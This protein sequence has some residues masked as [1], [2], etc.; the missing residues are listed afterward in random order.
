MLKR[1]HFQVPVKNA[2]VVKFWT[3]TWIVNTCNEGARDSSVWSVSV[4]LS[5]VHTKCVLKT[6][7]FP[8]FLGIKRI[9]GWYHFDKGK[10]LMGKLTI[11]VK[12]VH[13][14]QLD[15]T[16]WNIPFYSF[17]TGCQVFLCE[18]YHEQAWERWVNG[19]CNYKD[20]VLCRLRRVASAK[21]QDQCHTAVEQLKSS[22]IKK[23]KL[24]H[25]VG[26]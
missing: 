10:F 23:L 16:F 25:S 20:E 12:D 22:D 26:W 1:R 11:L 9:I 17:W 3:F 14:F 19:V 13:A 2:I 15:I 8:I 7:L 4:N 21:M 5:S 6:L 24:V 18:F